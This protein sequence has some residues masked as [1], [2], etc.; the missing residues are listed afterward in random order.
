MRFYFEQA[1][2]FDDTFATTGGTEFGEVGTDPN[3]KVGDKSVVGFARAMRGNGMDIIV[4]RERD[5]LDSLG[6]CANLIGFDYYG[7]AGTFVNCLFELFL[8][9]SDEIVSYEESAPWHTL[10]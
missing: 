2:V 8:I 5:E 4:T 1:I 10:P 3:S 9:G 6:D 7:S